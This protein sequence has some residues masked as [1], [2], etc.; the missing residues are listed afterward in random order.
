MTELSPTARALVDAAR[1]GLAPDPAAVRRMRANI[2]TAVGG[3]ALA[4]TGAKLA[5]GAKLAIVAAVA[6]ALVGGYV[7][8]R[9]SHESVATDTPQLS[10]PVEAIAV[11]PASPHL[12][13]APAVDDDAIEIEPTV[14]RVPKT[15]VATPPATPTPTSDVPVHAATTATAAD[16]H[17]PIADLAREV[18]LVDQAMAALRDGD[19]NGALGAIHRYDIETRG[20]GQ[21]AED[22]AATAKLAAFDA[23]WP[24]SGQRARVRATCQR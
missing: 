14:P 3:G 1:D 2:A 17:A 12:E 13:A 4:A 21:L 10:A 9:G 18:A 22:A 8:V 11:P 5:L 20:K 16:P 23:R 7:L 6:G 24:H 19:P 15:H